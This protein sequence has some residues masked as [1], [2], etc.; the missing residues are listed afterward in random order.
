MVLLL[1]VDFLPPEEL[2]RIFSI[3][4]E[5]QS[6][7]V[8]LHNGAVIVL[9][10]FETLEAGSEGQTLALN[11][12]RGRS[13]SQKLGGIFMRRRRSTLP[14]LKTWQKGIICRFLAFKPFRGVSSRPGVSSAAAAKQNPPSCVSISWLSPV[15]LPTA[16][17]LRIANVHPKMSLVPCPHPQLMTAPDCSSKR[18]LAL[19]QG[20]ARQCS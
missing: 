8:F 15:S 7:L 1:D 10:A 14:A 17:A 5:Y 9:P 18:T 4:S 16:E 12:A 2:M 3:G 19:G 11:L 6:T 20:K 13:A